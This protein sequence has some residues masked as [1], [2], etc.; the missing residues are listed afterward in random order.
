MCINLGNKIKL[1]VNN[2]T[3][4]N[5]YK[6]Y[7]CKFRLD[8]K[9]NYFCNRIINVWNSLS[10]SVVCCTSLLLFKY[11]LKDILIFNPS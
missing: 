3:R 4:G 2:N 6:L 11:K 7:K 5:M 10:N 9:K 1:S 8:V